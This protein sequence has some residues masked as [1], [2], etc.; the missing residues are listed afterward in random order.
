MVIDLN[1]FQ[2]PLVAI[3]RGL[4]PEHARAV[5]LVLFEAG[6][7][8]LEVPLNRRGALYCIE[9]IRRVAPSD[10]L[11]GGGT[12]LSTRDVDDVHDAGGQLMVAPHCD[13]DVMRRAAERGMVVVPGVATPTEAFNALRW[14]ASA[15]K[16]FPAD[17][18]GQAG[19]RAFKSVLP[20]GTHLWPVGGVAPED[21]APWVAAGAT[22]FGIGSQLFTP[23]LALGEVAG[24]AE[25]FLAA[26]AATTQAEAP[27]R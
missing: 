1:Q 14:R 24:R 12:M 27:T 18:V 4:A 2:P 11:I 23:E 25:R 17:M 26:W 3:L 6:F 7:R 15:L 20:S 19:L 22:G 16:V 9:A 13:A 10:A 21:I 8:I 5:A